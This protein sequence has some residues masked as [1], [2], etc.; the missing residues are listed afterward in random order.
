MLL[1]PSLKHFC[2]T[3]QSEGRLFECLAHRRVDKL[4]HLFAL[5]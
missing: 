3:F 5:V 4:T 2:F 1:K